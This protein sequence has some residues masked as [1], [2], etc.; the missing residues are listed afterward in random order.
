MD[1]K[2]FDVNGVSKEQLK[3]TLEL[4]LYDEYD[5]HAKVPSYTID[6]KKGFVLF[7]DATQGNKFP[8]PLGYPTL[9]DI[10]F[11]WIHSGV[12]KNM[13][14]IG[15]DANADHDGENDLGFRVYVE[16][17]GHVELSSPSYGDG[18]YAICAITP[19]WIWY[20]K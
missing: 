5:R 2:V 12:A 8:I 9:T 17:W 11:E 20:G 7:R 6:P 3:K 15:W 13:D 1:N 16:S 14:L 4:V 10:I 19:S 18:Q